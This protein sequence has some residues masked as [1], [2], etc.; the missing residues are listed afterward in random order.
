MGATKSMI[1]KIA[2]INHAL[3][4]AIK[5]LWVT[6]I[7]AIFVMVAACLPVTRKYYSRYVAK[8]GCWNILIIFLL[9]VL[10]DIWFLTTISMADKK[11]W[12]ILI[13]IN[14]SGII[15]IYRTY[16]EIKNI[17]QK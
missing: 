17:D 6:G 1:I 8:L 16:K 10:F 13:L 5:A 12:W 14:L 3:R 2:K 4:G 15:A 11:V 7:L 9:Y